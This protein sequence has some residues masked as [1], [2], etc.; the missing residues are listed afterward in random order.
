[1]TRNVL[2]AIVALQAAL[3][4]FVPIESSGQEPPA[5]QS[6]PDGRGG[7][8]RLRLGDLSFADEVVSFHK[9]DP[10]AADQHSI[11]EETLGSPNYDAS[12]DDEYLTLGCGGELVIRFTDNAL[13]DVDGP[14]IFVFEI[15]PAVEQ[16]SVAISKDGRTWTQVG[17]ISGGVAALDIR[18]AANPFDTYSFLKL[19]DDRTGCFGEWP[20]ADI[21]AIAAVGAGRRVTLDAAL[22][23]DVDESV[24]KPAAENTLRELATEINAIPTARVVVEGHT[25]G[26]GSDAHN[27]QLSEARAQAVR[28]FLVES[29]GV[30][31]DVVHARGYGETQPAVPN[32]TE[33]N[34]ARNRRVEVVIIVG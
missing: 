23:F 21:D 34:K 2:V 10:S 8:I 9:G 11:P 4:V 22:L 17:R 27:Q 32:D 28:Q 29:G 5:A 20:G 1:M 12:V 14:D 24:L 25:D 19:T 15:G 7:E 33:L 13:G 31:T 26:D 6:Y 30:M 3:V 16:T 18:G